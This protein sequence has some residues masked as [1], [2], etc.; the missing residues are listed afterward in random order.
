MTWDNFIA[1]A[2]QGVLSMSILYGVKKLGELATSVEKLNTN[3]ALL[4]ERD[5]NKGKQLEDHEDR[6]RVLEHK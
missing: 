1:W 6:I 4:I 2:F 3:V 5:V